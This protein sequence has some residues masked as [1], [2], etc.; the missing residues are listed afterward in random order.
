MSFPKELKNEVVVLVTVMG[1][2]VGRLKSNSG[3]HVVLKNPRLF[4]HNG[5][6]AGFVPGVSTSGEENP[7]ELVFFKNAI[8]TIT[9]ANKNVSDGWIQQTS[10]IIL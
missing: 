9:K 7:D 2:I 10:G 3:D 4:I 1:E 6:Q 5:E 8:L